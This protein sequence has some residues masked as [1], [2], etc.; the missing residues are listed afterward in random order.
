MCTVIQYDIL[1]FRDFRLFNQQQQ[2][3][4]TFNQQERLKSKVT[5]FTI[6]YDD[7]VQVVSVARLIH[8]IISYDKN[9]PPLWSQIAIY[10]LF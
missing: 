4:P 7:S 6:A 3:F 1:Q 10:A 8:K 9:L 2:R 5:D